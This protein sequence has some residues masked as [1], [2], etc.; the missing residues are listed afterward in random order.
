MQLFDFRA[1][2]LR[3]VAGF[4][5]KPVGRAQEDKNK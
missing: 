1:R 5:R 3:N 2:N 4:D